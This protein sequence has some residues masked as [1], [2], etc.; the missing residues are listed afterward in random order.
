G[1]DDLAF[2][3]RDAESNPARWVRR[4]AHQAVERLGNVR[5]SAPIDPVLSGH[6]AADRFEEELHSGFLEDHAT[7]SKLYC[8]DNLGS[9][10]GSR[11]ND[12]FGLTRGV[13]QLFQYFHTG[14]SGR[15]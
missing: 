6:D 1:R 10:N 3:R 5:N 13:R 9:L 15:R 11:K 2:T 8:L 12:S 4:F 7:R 14:A